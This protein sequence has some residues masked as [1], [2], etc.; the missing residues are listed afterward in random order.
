MGLAQGLDGRVGVAK[1]LTSGTGRRRWPF[2][3]WETAGGGFG[4]ESEHLEC[5]RCSL[6]GHRPSAI[7]GAR[8]GR[9]SE[10]GEGSVG[11]LKPRGGGRP[12][13]LTCRAGR[14]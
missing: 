2:T 11:F 5:E 10:E 9:D 4:V 14:A 3:L 7:A 1:V 12:V 6:A 8:K 13:L